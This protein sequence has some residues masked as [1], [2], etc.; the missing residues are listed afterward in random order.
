MVNVDTVDTAEP[1]IL[2][3]CYTAYYTILI[4]Y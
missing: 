3:Y 4:I 1:V 2:F